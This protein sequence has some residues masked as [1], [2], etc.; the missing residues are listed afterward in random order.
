MFSV[1]LTVASIVVWTIQSLKVYLSSEHLSLHLA[2][3]Q[4]I[5]TWKYFMIWFIWK[6]FS[7]VSNMMSTVLL[8]IFL[9][10]HLLFRHEFGNYMLDFQ[11]ISRVDFL[12]T[13]SNLD[14]QPNAKYYLSFLQCMQMAIIISID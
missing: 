11:N 13:L 4:L 12:V 7:V 9:W 10:L 2:K 5:S 3:I 14:V 1:P 8:L 6:F